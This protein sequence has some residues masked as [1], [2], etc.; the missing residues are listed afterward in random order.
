[1]RMKIEHKIIISNVF[2]VAL[3]LLTGLF[4]IQNMN[5]VLTK[6]RFVEIAD[7]LNASLLEMRISEKNYFLYGDAGTLLEIKDKIKSASLAL[8]DEKKDI[9]RAVGSGSL[10]QMRNILRNT[11][12][13]WT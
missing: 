13:R 9:V 1:M 3:I 11:Q 4:A 6:L 5:N 10:S 7:D 12:R 2:N 8:D